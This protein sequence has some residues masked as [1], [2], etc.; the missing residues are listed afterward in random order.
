MLV[1]PPFGELREVIDDGVAVR[2]EDVRAVFVIEDPGLV[3]LVIGIAA[4]V[5]SPVDQQ[6]PRAALAGEA[7]GKD[8][9]GEAGADNQVVVGWAAFGRGGR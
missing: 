3:L 1:G 4:D 7:F 5:V 2:V 9:A 6:D 8:R